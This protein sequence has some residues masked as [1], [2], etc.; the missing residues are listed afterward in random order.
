MW[1]RTQ[2]ADA[3]P[4][5]LQKRKA[6]TRLKG[7]SL[8][9][10]LHEVAMYIQALCHVGKIPLRLS[11]WV[12]FLQEELQRNDKQEKQPGN[13]EEKPIGYDTKKKKAAFLLQNQ[14][15]RF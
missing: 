15:G 2:P 9:M 6:F 14:R 1:H 13:S 11:K 5:S 3:G 12:N 10:T 7:W 4:K 8:R